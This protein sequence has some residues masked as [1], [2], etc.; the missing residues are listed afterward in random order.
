MKKRLLCLACLM[1]LMIWA[2]PCQA[3][4]PVEW[5]LEWMETGELRETARIPGYVTEVPAG[6]EWSRVQEND[7][8]VY[9]RNVQ[10]WSEYQSY[11]DGL[12]LIINENKNILY[13]LTT[14]ETDP[15]FRG[16][17]FQQIAG[18]NELQLT[19][20]VPGFI[21]TSTAD[22]RNDLLSSWFFAQGTDLGSEGLILK[23]VRVDGL[24]LGM[25]IVTIGIILAVLIFYRRL[26]RAQ[27]IIA[28]TFA[29]PPKDDSQTEEGSK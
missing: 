1:T 21:V 27:Q 10:G 3:A 13:S 15:Q 2:L 9:Y 18:A 17:W 22:Q 11:D 6:K 12:P 26:K 16:D 28:E 8:V 14:I 25:G 24:V 4:S 5:Q 29:M 23:V 20:E 7:D 19:I